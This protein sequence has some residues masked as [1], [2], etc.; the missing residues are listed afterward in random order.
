V[1][2][3]TAAL[4]GC[5]RGYPRSIV[6]ALND[7][8]AAVTSIAS[9]DA[10]DSYELEL[11]VH[12]G[13]DGAP[14]DSSFTLFNVPAGEYVVL[15]AYENDSLVKDPDTNIA[16]TDFVHV[17]V[18]AGQAT[19]ALPE[20]FKITEALAIT[21]PGAGHP[22][23]V[24]AAPM[25]I[26]ADDSSEDWYEVRVFDAFGDE[27]WSVLDVPGVS[28]SAT[29]ELQYAGPLEPGMY[30]QFRVTSWR[31]AGAGPA[32]AIST[33]EALQGVFFTAP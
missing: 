12:R 29:V 13:A 33:T 30:H 8:G 31:Q 11:P 15:A 3:L 6:V 9:T 20:S 16:G 10:D 2:A 23:A 28:G 27:V 25:L 24:T 26:W 1:L 21:S 19:A 17:T 4:P 7:K 14:I 22:E 5:R 18:S 32:S